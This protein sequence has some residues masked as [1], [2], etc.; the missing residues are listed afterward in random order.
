M[1]CSVMEDR[2]GDCKFVAFCKRYEGH[3]GLVEVCSVVTGV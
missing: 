2:V 3:F 1:V